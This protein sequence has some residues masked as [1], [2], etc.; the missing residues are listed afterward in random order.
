[1][2]G[3]PTAY[4]GVPSVWRGVHDTPV[5]ASILLGRVQEVCSAF[6]ARSRTKRGGVSAL[7]GEQRGGGA[8]ARSATLSQRVA[9]GA[10]VDPT[11][12][13]RTARACRRRAGV[14]PA[15]AR[16]CGV[17]VRDVPAARLLA[18]GPGT[19]RARLR[20]NRDGHDRQAAGVA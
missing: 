11:Y 10:A 20:R 14:R 15:D 4:G 5:G 6:A 2:V 12:L 7:S 16:S 13:R 18:A 1:M 19:R 17:D 3:N 9:R 8:M